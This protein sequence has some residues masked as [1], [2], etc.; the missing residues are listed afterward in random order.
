VS[1][2]PLLQC[3]GHGIILESLIKE[4]KIPDTGRI[5]YAAGE[6]QRSVWLMT[7]LQ[8]FPTWNIDDTETCPANPPSS[9]I[10]LRA[11]ITGW[12][13]YKNFM[14][15]FVSKVARENPELYIVSVSPGITPTGVYDQFSQPMRGIVNFLGGTNDVESAGDRYVDAATSE[16][17]IYLFK[18]GSVIMSPMTMRYLCATGPLTDNTIE[19]G[20]ESFQDRVAECLRKE[21]AKCEL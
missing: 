5:I 15:M 14:A 16:D 20:D 10:D 19:F 4:K 6:L 13:H 21:I 12:Q 1:P 2:R 18:T 9:S 8:P 3:I 17:F 11:L 7:G